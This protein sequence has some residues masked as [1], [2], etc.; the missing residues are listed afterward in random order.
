MDLAMLLSHNDTDDVF[1]NDRC[2]VTGASDIDVSTH[3]QC[4]PQHPS[5]YYESLSSPLRQRYGQQRPM[6]PISRDFL[7]VN[8]DASGLHRS[9]T[10][11]YDI[12]SHISRHHRAW[13]KAE[14]QKK[15]KSSIIP[16][17]TGRSPYKT[18]ETS[19]ALV[20]TSSNT[21]THAT[22]SPAADRWRTQHEDESDS[23]QQYP[24]RSQRR[25]VDH[26]TRIQ[27][28][29]S[30]SRLRSRGSPAIDCLI[31]RGSTDPF[32]AAALN[33][34]SHEAAAISAAS[35][36]LVVRYI[37]QFCLP[38]PRRSLLAEL[39]DLPFRYCSLDDTRSC[40]V[41]AFVNSRRSSQPGLNKPTAFSVPD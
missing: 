14:R 4:S 40:I 34:G 30:G 6:A 10:E 38:G 28:Y 15:L 29:G 18:G 7:F 2:L 23:S 33:I 36:F 8:K 24:Y 21:S 5:R 25:L 39:Y 3:H 11:S 27:N 19:G 16:V 35:Q 9:T 41:L 1:G 13:L 20:A 22:A 31:H 12:T 37:S 17:S 32:S 26:G